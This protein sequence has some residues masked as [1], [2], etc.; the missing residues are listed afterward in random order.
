MVASAGPEGRMAES[1]D[2]VDQDGDIYTCFRV[3]LPASSG[4]VVLEADH[5]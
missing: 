4:D 5:E 3:M 2:R 1:E